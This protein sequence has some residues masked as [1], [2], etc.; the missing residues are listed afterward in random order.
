MTALV[1]YIYPNAVSFFDEL[2]ASILAQTDKDFEVIFF[3]DGVS[4][5][6]FKN[7][8][9]KHLFIPVEGTPLEIR[10]K[11]FEILKTL[12]YDQFIF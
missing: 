7:I 9:F 8:T 1:V 5:N 11:S 2:C 12:P 6:F 10:F 4:D 3:N